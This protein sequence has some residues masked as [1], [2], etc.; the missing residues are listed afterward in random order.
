MT[1]P[2]GPR[3]GL[4]APK[5]PIP[6][7]RA[8]AWPWPAGAVP[9]KQRAR[10]GRALLGGRVD[11]QRP[12]RRPGGRAAEPRAVER[13]VAGTHR[14]C[15]PGRGTLGRVRNVGWEQSQPQAAGCRGIGCDG[16]G[17][18]RHGA[19][20][21]RPCAKPCSLDMYAVHVEADVGP[22]WGVPSSPE[23]GGGGRPAGDNWGAGKRP[24]CLS[25]SGLPFSFSARSAC[26]V[27]PHMRSS[28][29]HG[30]RAYHRDV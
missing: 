19:S 18:L 15:A 26:H 6:R 17:V 2:G 12:A 28:L 7:C 20:R 25:A 1:P 24:R 5:R 30:C 3:S 8:C 29:L 23:R 16:V 10:R 21:R 14:R 22:R 11:R 27:P 4:Q 9:R 13:A